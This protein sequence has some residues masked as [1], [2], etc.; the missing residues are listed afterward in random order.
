MTDIFVMA[1]EHSYAAFVGVLSNIHMKAH[2]SSPYRD[3][4]YKALI[5]VS[6]SMC[7][8]FKG[9]PESS[10]DRLRVISARM[11]PPDGGIEIDFHI[12]DNPM[13][14]PDSPG[15]LKHTVTH[16]WPICSTVSGE[17][18]TKNPPPRS[19][20]SGPNKVR[21]F[22]LDCPGVALDYNMPIRKVLDLLGRSKCHVSY[23]GGTAWLSVCMGIPTIIVHA[24]RPLDHLHYKAKLFG[25]DTNINAVRD[26]MVD[27]LRQH[28]METHVTLDQL[29]AALD[30]YT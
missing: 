24:Y 10:I 22:K 11:Q 2:V 8:P 25:Q 15:G 20:D 7:E 9:Q 28:P 4:P 5:V 27:M 16:A 3:N 30:D 6:P 19:L 14:H 12:D 1:N 17:I 13:F 18:I 29:P 23:Q 26:G 21:Y